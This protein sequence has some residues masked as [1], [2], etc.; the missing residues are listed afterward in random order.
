[1][2]AGES[3][4]TEQ[5]LSD[6]FLEDVQRVRPSTPPSVQHLFAASP[7]AEPSPEAQP[8]PAQAKAPEEPVACDAAP[9]RTLGEA[10]IEL[11]RAALDAAK[12]NISEA[13]KRLGIS[14]N[15]IY[16]KLRWGKS[17]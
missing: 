2:A 11:I 4:I 16:R 6:D 17:E 1:M 7:A 8:A 13:S 10:E 9:A 12:G 14:R 15:T 5:H 3:Q